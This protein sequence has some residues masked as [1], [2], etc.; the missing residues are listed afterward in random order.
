MK[1]HVMLT[2]LQFA[3]FVRLGFGELL[4]ALVCLRDDFPWIPGEC[5][6]AAAV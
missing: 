1:I 6:V 2:L 4:A 3:R 5:S